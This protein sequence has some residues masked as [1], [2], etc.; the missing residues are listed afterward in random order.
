MQ[1][2]GSDRLLRRFGQE[3]AGLHCE[4]EDFFP[5]NLCVLYWRSETTPAEE[6]VADP[7]EDWPRVSAGH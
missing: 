7:A 6:V 1:L 5:A 2:M 4:V 3:D